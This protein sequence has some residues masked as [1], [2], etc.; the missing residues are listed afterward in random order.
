MVQP[1][2]TVLNTFLSNFL[3]FVG[4]L[5]MCFVTSWRLSILAITSI[6]P[7]IQITQA[8]AK[9]SRQ[10]NKEV[11]CCGA[12]AALPPVARLLP[13]AELVAVLTL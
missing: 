13:S 11:K 9:W 4:G 7:I 5:V 10:I 1:C 3:L 12:A 8:Y 2:Q 6:G